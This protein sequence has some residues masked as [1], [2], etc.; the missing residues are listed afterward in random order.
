[1]AKI[2]PYAPIEVTHYRLK[3]KAPHTV[4]SHFPIDPTNF[5][6]PFSKGGFSSSLKLTL[7]IMSK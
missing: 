1:M 5:L 7:R 2:I 4:L 3:R 6:T